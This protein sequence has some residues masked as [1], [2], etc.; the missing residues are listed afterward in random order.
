[1]K[2]I[3]IF[4]SI[5]F[6]NCSLFAQNDKK[7]REPFKLELGVDKEQYYSMDVQ[8]SPYFVKENILQIYPG[9]KLLV[10]TELNQKDEFISMKVVKENLNPDKTIEIEFEQ[11]LL[12]DG[13]KQ[14][15][16]TV[17]NP[18]EKEMKY[19]ALMFIVGHDKWV[20][21]SII[22]ILPKLVNYEMWSDVI[23]SLVLEGWKLK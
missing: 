21:T 23:I 3:L 2:K 14:M 4:I 12:E 8:K 15:F 18:F 6:F 10:E 20:E 22:P 19:E 13:K 11:K 16:L 5:L 17:K 7:E 9:E 1:M